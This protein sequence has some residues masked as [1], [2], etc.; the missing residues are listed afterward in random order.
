MRVSPQTKAGSERRRQNGQ[1]IEWRP[2]DRAKARIG[3]D[4]RIAIAAVVEIAAFAE[5]RVYAG[6]AN[7]LKRATVDWSVSAGMPIA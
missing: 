6:R 3:L 5:I 4:V 1:G 7:P 2:G